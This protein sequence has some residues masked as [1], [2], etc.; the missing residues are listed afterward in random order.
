MIGVPVEAI[1]EALPPPEVRVDAL[2]GEAVESVH[3]LAE[4]ARVDAE[5]AGELVEGIGASQPLRRRLSRHHR[6]ERV[7][8]QIGV[9]EDEPRGEIRALV[10]IGLEGEEGLHEV[11]VV[12]R[13]VD[14]AAPL[15]V[16]DDGVRERPRGEVAPVELLAVVLLARD[17][18][19]RAPPG[20]A[21]V[22]EIRA[23]GHGH[24]EPVALV[25]GGAVGMGEHAAEEL[26]RERPV[27]LEAA[28]RE[29]DP[30][31]CAHEELLSLVLDAYPRD[32]PFLHHELTSDMLE[33][34]LDLAV[35][36]SLE[37]LSRERAAVTDEALAVPLSEELERELQRLGED[38]PVRRL[39]HGH[40]GHPEDGTASQTLLPRAEIVRV[41][42]ARIER[43]PSGFAAGELGVIIGIPRECL[44]AEWRLGLDPRDHRRCGV[45]ETL[46]QRVVGAPVGQAF[47][48]GQRL[49]ARVFDADF[50]EVVVVR[51]P[52]D[53]AR[54]GRR[55]A[56]EARLLEEHD[57]RARGVGC[58]GG[59]HPG[60]ARAE[61][62]HVGLQVPSLLLLEPVHRR[63]R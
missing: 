42:E 40:R 44:E 17:D 19:R 12:L 16:D 7:L 46:D 14:E 61:G 54:D 36:E 30:A 31:P 27:P 15:L 37:E 11:V 49:G 20:L 10:G 24:L 32:T 45:D 5:D 58:E 22:R 48:V 57:A 47:H 60:G 29:N 53:A 62:Q 63:S 18:E 55:P 56:D 8:L 2:D 25:A 13:L 9:V 34:R 6:H 33:A 26:R 1:V 52:D 35:E 50:G 28:R 3:G 39:G 23:D 51:H 38:A 4:A 21:H 43:A 59:G 41:E